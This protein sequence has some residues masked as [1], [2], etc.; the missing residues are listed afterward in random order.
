MSLIT[1]TGCNRHFTHA[2]YSRHLSM[3]TRALCRAIY[4]RRLDRPVVWDHPGVPGLENGNPSE[5][6]CWLNHASRL[7]LHFRRE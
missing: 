3:T 6:R 2:G 1:C 4:D 7:T 5:C